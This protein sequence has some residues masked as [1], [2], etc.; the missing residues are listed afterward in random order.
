M[1]KLYAY[2]TRNVTVVLYGISSYGN[3]AQLGL[4]MIEKQVLRRIFGSK[5]DEKA[6][7]GLLRKKYSQ[8]IF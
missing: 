2:K 8:I 3:K 5:K 6:K 7:I 4:R 1:I